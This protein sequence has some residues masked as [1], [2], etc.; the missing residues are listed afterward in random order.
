MAKD[1]LTR[2]N[3]DSHYITQDLLV[4]EI[5]IFFKHTLL[6]LAVKANAYDLV[7]LS[8]FQAL[9][10]DIWYDRVNPHTSNIRVKLL[11]FFLLLKNSALQL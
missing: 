6:E 7:C 9:L 2:C 3:D 11:D 5:E 10:T 1:I 8:P 4:C